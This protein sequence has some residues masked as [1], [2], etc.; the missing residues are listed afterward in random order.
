MIERTNPKG[1]KY[2][3]PTDPNDAALLQITEGSTFVETV[4]PSGW[5]SPKEEHIARNGVLVE[6][7]Q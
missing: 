3:E 6:T 4:F 1:E 5:K 2:W 7:I